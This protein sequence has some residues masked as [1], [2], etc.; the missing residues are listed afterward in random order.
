MGKFTWTNKALLEDV[1]KCFVFESLLT[2]HSNVLS[3]HLKQTFPSIIWIFTEGDR[4]ESRPS[5]KIF[6]T[7]RTA[8]ITVFPWFLISNCIYLQCT[9]WGSWLGPSQQSYFTG[10]WQFGKV[11]IFPVCQKSSSLHSG[12]YKKTSESCFFSLPDIIW[13]KL[14]GVF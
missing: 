14:L 10:N 5:F 11:N 6:S 12:A 2:M 1:N 3:L 8:Q 13:P 9:F 4:I 7:L